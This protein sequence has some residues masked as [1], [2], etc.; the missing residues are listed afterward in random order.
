VLAF[1]L[2][3]L[4]QK[5]LADSGI[6]ISINKMLNATGEIKRVTTF[7]GNIDKPE[8]VDSFTEGEELSQQVESTFKLKEK[9]S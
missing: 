3:C 9:Y 2:C 5:E 7:F 1:W 8:K 6:N 4:L